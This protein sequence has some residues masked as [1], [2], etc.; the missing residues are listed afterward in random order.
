[1]IAARLASVFLIAVFAVTVN[2][3]NAAKQD[4]LPDV[5]ISLQ[6][7]TPNVYYVQGAS[8]V[9]TDNAGFVSNAGFVVTGEGVVV[10]D[11]LGTPALAQR[12][13]EL[14]RSVTERPV[15]FVVLSHFHADHAYGLQVFEELGAEIL[16][17][18]GSRD[19]LSA[20][21]AGE[22]LE[23]RRR[24]LVPWVNEQ[25]RLVIPDRF[26]D[27]DHRFTLGQHAFVA[28][29]L[30]SAH[31]EGDMTLFVEPDNVLFS[32]DIIF[33]GRIPFLGS[34][35]T[36][37]WLQT[38]RRMQET[39]VAALIPGHGPARENPRE[40][41]ALTT[42]YLAYMR[43]QMGKAVEDWVPFDEAYEQV[44]WD[45]FMEYPAFL[46]ANRRNA[47]AVYLSLEAEA[48]QGK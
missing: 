14:V 15:R 28:S 23:E 11:A 31:S 46:E 40:M 9:A 4:P 25:T 19:Y 34:A 2:I 41:L 20:D 1:M 45:E 36:R 35:N 38:L 12:L 24:S 7:V 18:A 42:R 17:S 6:Q 22:R 27:G 3:G 8:G 48:L 13:I 29:N 43:E 16:A 44:D 37:N 10:F 47:Y 32:G 21:I 33:E 5:Q 30:G 39:D 26:I